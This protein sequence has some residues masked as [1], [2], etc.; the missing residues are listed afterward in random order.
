M[1]L[2]SL[3]R[4]TLCATV[5]LT[6][7]ALSIL[8]LS[9]R[10]ASADEP[11]RFTFGL[12]GDVP[13]AKASNAAEV[14]TM[15]NDM[16]AANLAFSIYDGD[17]WDGSTRC[18][19]ASYGEAAARFNSLT[20]PMV[21]VVGDN[22]WTDC[23]RIASGGF[24]PLERLDYL[25]KLMFSTVNSF[26]K[27]TMPLE[28]QAGPGQKYAENTRWTYGNV[29]FIGVDMPGS[30]NNFLLDSAGCAD[31]SNRTLADC[32]AANLEA[33]QRDAA[34]IDWLKQSFVMAKQR[35]LAGVMIVGQADLGF[36][37]PETPVDERSA[38][39]VSGYTRF[40]LAMIAETQ[41]YKGQVVYV[42]G[43]THFFKVDKPLAIDPAVKPGANQYVVGDNAR[44]IPNFTRVQTFG[45]AN[46]AWVKV[47]IDP[48][49]RNL[50]VFEPM[51]P[52]SLAPTAAGPVAA[53][54]PP[55]SPS[56]PTATATPK[57]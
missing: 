15:I 26:G 4:P 14:P 21:Y 39:G 2:N 44:A 50:F 28:H 29:M 48:T 47:T 7:L 33:T 30:N 18:D 46:V 56:T 49:S 12:W 17:L 36:D 20:S 5:A 3:R 31:K 34:N 1:P 16:N 55:G 43:D 10:H 23:H 41:A 32:L 38:P 35:N 42:H 22:E 27:T 54:T 40:L 53:A 19:N 11:Q 45:S 9:V 13:Y 51:I 6:V 25:R 52:N 24:D 37:V 8:G 57:P